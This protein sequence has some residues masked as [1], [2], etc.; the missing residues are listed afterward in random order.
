MATFNP[1]L[2]STN[3]N[4]RT[5]HGVRLLAFVICSIPNRRFQSTH[6]SRGATRRCPHAPRICQISI[7]A[8]LTGCDILLLCPTG[9][10]CP[11]S[12][13][14]PLTGCDTSVSGKI[15]RILY[16]NPRTPHGV[17][18]CDT[19]SVKYLATF[20]STH[21][22]RG[23]T[24]DRVQY[25]KRFDISIHAPLTGCDTSRRT[26]PVD[27]RDFNPRTPHGVRHGSTTDLSAGSVHFNPR[28]P[29]GVRQHLL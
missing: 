29:H 8:P 6:P 16:F 21:P 26:Y 20:Q 25:V 2:D 11:I 14:A 13:H 4:P 18:H 27:V 19:D 23:A 10:Y 24:H 3:F 9:K 7:H 22:S 12:I 1:R 28:T 17:R 5:P 15:A